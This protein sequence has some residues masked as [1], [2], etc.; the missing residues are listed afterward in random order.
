MGVRRYKL[1]IWKFFLSFGLVFF[2]FNV[3]MFVSWNR[4]IDINFNFNFQLNLCRFS[5]CW[6]TNDELLQMYFSGILS[7]FEEHLYQETPFFCVLLA[8]SYFAPRLLPPISPILCSPTKNPKIRSLTT[9]RKYA[10]KC[11]VWKKTVDVKRKQFKKFSSK[12]W[13]DILS[14]TH[15]QVKV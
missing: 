9:Y 13:W 11:T 10:K 5:T 15:K 1:H 3:I 14:G 2:C 6:F 7:I 4:Y 12:I 8:E